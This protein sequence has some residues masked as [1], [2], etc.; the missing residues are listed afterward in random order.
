L[1]VFAEINCKNV[2]LSKYSARQTQFFG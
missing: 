1:P 2:I